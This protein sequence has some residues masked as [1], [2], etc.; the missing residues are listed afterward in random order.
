MFFGLHTTKKTERDLLLER[1][2]EEIEISPQDLHTSELNKPIVIEE[3]TGNLYEHDIKDFL[4]LCKAVQ[5]PSYDPLE[6]AYYKRYIHRSSDVYT[7]VKRLRELIEDIKEKGIQ[8]PVHVE[9]TGERLDGSYRTKIAQFLG[10]KRV[11]AII[12]AFKWEDIDEDFIERKLRARW[13][14]SGKDYYEFEYGYKDWRNIPKGGDVYRENALERWE[15]IKP[16]LRGKVQDLGCNEGYMSLMAAKE[17]HEVRGYD[18]DWIHIAWL[19]KLIFEWIGNKDLP[20]TF[21]EK[22]ILKVEPWGD[23]VL[24]LCVIYHLPVDK[25]VK[26]L[27]KFRGKRIIFQCNLRKSEK[28]GIY[29]GSHPD[30]L[31]ALIKE[32]GLKVIAEIGFRDKPIIIAG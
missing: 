5:D 10:I 15:V 24:M 21:E 6:S 16:L 9:R 4:D 32:A 18:L 2:G 31:K 3:D 1:Q 19:N 28:R 26:F 25:Q 20:V 8:A 27:Q 7:R 22:D 23:T 30:D 12:H 29:W 17:G 13:E 14:S 11:K